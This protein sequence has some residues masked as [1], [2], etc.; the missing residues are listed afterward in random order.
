LAVGNGD[1]IVHKN[2]GIEPCRVAFT[3][4]HLGRVQAA[5]RA[6]VWDRQLPGDGRL[7][8]AAFA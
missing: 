1:P 6:F 4:A 2:C 3:I 7:I 5:Q 8:V